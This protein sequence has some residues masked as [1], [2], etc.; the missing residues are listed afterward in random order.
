MIF[1]NEI[2][3]SASS[4]EYLR[5]ICWREEWVHPY[6]S[7]ISIIEKIKVANV[8]ESE[9]I[10]RGLG[11]KILREQR[12]ITTAAKNM[13]L[14]T[15]QSF[16]DELFMYYTNYD[17]KKQKELIKKVC[18]SSYV[19]RKTYDHFSKYLKYCEEC[20][21]YHFHSIFHQLWAVNVCPFHGIS[22]R[23]TCVRCNKTRSYS[24][25]YGDH[26]RCYCGYSFITENSSG[27]TIW[28]NWGREFE[29]KKDIFIWTYI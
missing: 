27:R 6:E 24:F 19:G 1:I 2:A 25:K 20:L 18:N 10:I 23:D 11:T 14:Y 22:L 21:E 29:I 17:L 16:D 7:I 3:A 8:I 12:T 9:D 4:S 15:M 5:K 28:A 26:F 13:D